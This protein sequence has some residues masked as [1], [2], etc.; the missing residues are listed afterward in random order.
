M[1]PPACNVRVVA[2]ALSGTVH[3]V[4]RVMFPEAC[5]RIWEK[6]SSELGFK[7]KVD[8]E[9]PSLTV[10]ELAVE[11]E[12]L[13]VMLTGSMINLPPVQPSLA[14]P[15]IWDWMAPIWGADIST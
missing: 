9:S 7:V 8:G 14:C 3:G 13:R 10:P 15:L 5:S 1:L 2:L 6:E 4:A 12:A 11:P